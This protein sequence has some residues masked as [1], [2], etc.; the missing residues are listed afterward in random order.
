MPKVEIPDFAVVEF[1]DDM[2]E[3][4]IGTAIREDIYKLPPLPSPVL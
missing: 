1:P 2:T 4:Q 3:A